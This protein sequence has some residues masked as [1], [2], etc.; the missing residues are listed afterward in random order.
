[1]NTSADVAPGIAVGPVAGYEPPQIDAQWDMLYWQNIQATLAN[2]LLLGGA[3]AGGYFWVTGGGSSSGVATDNRIYRLTSAGAVVDSILQPN[4]GSGWG[5]R[6]MAFDGTYLYGGCE[7]TVITAW[8]LTGAMVPV[9][10]ATKPAGAAIVRALAYDPITDSFWTGNFG[11]ALFNF[12]RTGT[13]IWTGPTAPLT[14]VYGMVWDDMGT[15]GPWLWIYDQTGTPGTKY[16]QF[17]PTTH[18]FTG[19]T[20]NVPLFGGL[21]ANIAGGAEWS[22]DYSPTVASIVAVGQGTAFDNLYVLEMYP[23]GGTPT[24]ILNL[25]YTSGSPVAPGGGDLLYNA[26]LENDESVSLPFQYWATYTQG[27]TVVPAFGPISRISP[28]GPNYHINRD[29]TQTVAGSLGSG[30][31]TYTGYIGSYP[32]GVWASD[33]FP[34]TKSAVG[35]GGTYYFEN[36]LTGWDEEPAAVNATPTNF[37]LQGNYPNPFNPTTTINFSLGSADNVKLSV[38][39]LSGRLVSTLVD[40][41]RE[42]GSHA[43]SFDATGLASGVYVYRLTAGAQ[44][45]SAKMILSK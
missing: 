17:N 7:S 31:W 28:A 20:Y 32:G 34:F 11:S 43:V 35:D 19:V 18:A 3:Y 45:A 27:A 10:N 15:G 41:Y 42:A 8:D 36:T 13:I 4:V 14:A 6:D 37:A 5:F 33:S 12:T 22:D 30:D 44:T 25:T 39:D 24:V 1:M 38:Y 2:Q 16:H 23:T 9:M 26:D 29:L 21:T 40:G